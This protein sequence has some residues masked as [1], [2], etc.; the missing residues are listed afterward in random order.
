MY[1]AAI[2]LFEKPVRHVV[3]VLCVYLGWPGVAV[4]VRRECLHGR[5]YHGSARLLR[6]QLLRTL[7]FLAL[8]GQL[9]EIPSLVLQRPGVP[10]LKVPDVC[11][12]QLQL[13]KVTRV[14][15][16]GQRWRW[17]FAARR[18][19][20]PGPGAPPTRTPRRGMQ[21]ASALGGAYRELS[22][23]LHASAMPGVGPARRRVS[24]A[25]AA[26]LLAASTRAGSFS[27]TA[28]PSAARS[29]HGAP[30]VG[31]RTARIGP[32]ACSLF[33][34]CGLRLMRLMRAATADSVTQ[35]ESHCRTHGHVAVDGFPCCCCASCRCFGVVVSHFWHII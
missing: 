21:A 6:L 10:C 32:G 25:I 29:G 8:L 1:H 35:S 11:S 33:H 15:M 27:V 16:V 2:I 28:V 30:G 18:R 4:C 22:L 9:F 17:R 20:Q 26:S 3:C 23:W 34:A 12:T 5:V 13:S 24:R 19:A 31:C 7:V 14:R